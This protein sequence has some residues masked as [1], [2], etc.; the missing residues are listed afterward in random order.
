MAA[1]DARPQ[2]LKHST[3][4]KLRTKFIEF[5]LET[6][7]SAQT[8]GGSLHQTFN[9][10]PQTPENCA[11]SEVTV[12][13][14]RRASDRLRGE[15]RIGATRTVLGTISGIVPNTF[16][17]AMWTSAFTGSLMRTAL[18]EMAG[19]SSVCATSASD[20][21]RPFCSPRRPASLQ[22]DP[23]C[24]NLCTRLFC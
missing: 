16:F 20:P 6:R 23:C 19:D 14:S 24:G 1:A 17:W 18:P 7:F 15:L 12:V 2:M 9:I 8:N 11:L 22:S 13:R 4:Q 10:R 3:S 21:R 5:P